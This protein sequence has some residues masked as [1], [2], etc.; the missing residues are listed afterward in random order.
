MEQRQA[1]TAAVWGTRGAVCMGAEFLEYGG[2]T[3]CVSVDCGGELVVFDAGSGIVRLGGT[4]SGGRRIHIFFS[5]LHLDHILGLPDFGP[6]HDPEAEL[7][8]YGE[9]RDGMSFRQQLERFLGPPYWPLG[10]GDFPARIAVHEIVPGACVALA[11]GLSVSTLRGNHPNGSL[12]CRLE[13][14][15]KRAVYALDCEMGGGMSGR[16]AEFARGCDL[17]I[18]DAT[19]TAGDLRRGWGHSTWEQGAAVGQAAGAGLTLMTHFSPA[20]NDAFLRKQEE[21]AGRKSAAVRFAREGM[22]LRL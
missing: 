6:L 11:E 8:L 21:L 14:A 5:H 22:T 12:L 15:G 13:G 18:W 4:L 20:Y 9:A 16:L 3:S 19:F 17:L 2:N 1:W 7:H 10:L